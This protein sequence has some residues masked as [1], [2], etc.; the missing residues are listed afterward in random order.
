MIAKDLMSENPTTIQESAAV[1]AVIEI[2]QEQGFRHLPV[3]R[4]S[5][6]VGML[7]DRDLRSLMVP[8]L[9]DDAGLTE[10]QARYSATVSELVSRDVVKVNPDADAGDIIDLMLEYKVGAVPVVDEGS[11]DLLGIVSYV[12]ILREGRD[13]LA[14]T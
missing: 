10:L 3:L 2:F 8:K 6:L 4:G 12:D 13:A 11:G 14:E 5:E 7:S 1:G 9:V